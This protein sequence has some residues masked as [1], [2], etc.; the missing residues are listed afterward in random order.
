VSSI[1]NRVL[2]SCVCV[3]FS[4]CVFVCVCVRVCV[5]VCV[6]LFG[7]FVVVIDLDGFCVF[8]SEHL[9]VRKSIC[10]GVSIGVYFIFTF[11]KRLISN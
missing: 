11:K 2:L 10:L 6:C 8:V 9:L 5:C 3:S 7:C 4:L 1:I